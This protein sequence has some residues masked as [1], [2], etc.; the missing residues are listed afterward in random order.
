MVL[1]DFYQYSILKEVEN[2]GSQKPTKVLEAKLEV[3]E[4]ENID[5]LIGLTIRGAV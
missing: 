2:E 3:K 1:V 4:M 5:I